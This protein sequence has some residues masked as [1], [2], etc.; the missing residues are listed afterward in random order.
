MTPWLVAAEPGFSE[1]AVP[2]W[3]CLDT[4]TYRAQRVRRLLQTGQRSA[5]DMRA[6]L[7]DDTATAA[8]DTVPIL[9]KAAEEQ[10]KNLASAHPDLPAAI[11]LL[12]DWNRR[13]STDA[14]GMA[15]YNVWWNMVRERTAATLPT[16]AA[17]YAFLKQ[18]L[19]ESR[20]LALDAA[21]DAVRTLRNNLDRIDPVWGEVH[22]IVRGARE[23]AISGAMS[24]EPVFVSGDTLFERG[25]WRAA[26]GYG[27][28]MIVQF[29]P[30]PSAVSIVPFGASERVVSPH[31]TDQLDLFREK[32]FKHTRYREEDVLRHVESAHGR[33]LTFYPAGVPGT[34]VIAAPQAV[35]ASV[36]VSPTPPEPLTPGIT[37]FSLYAKPVVTPGDIVFQTT[38]TIA[39]VPE[40][41]KNGDTSVLRL[42]GYAPGVGW[43]ELAGQQF[44]A[45]SN[46]F[47]ASQ[48]GGGVFALLGPEETLVVPSLEPAPVPGKPKAPDAKKS[49][50]KAPAPETPQPEAA[51]EEAAPGEATPAAPLPED[52]MTFVPDA[53]AAKDTPEAADGK[54]P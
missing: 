11:A 33:R 18:D 20:Q 2:K 32:R 10:Q 51:P 30:A 45:P 53:N 5:A 34:I 38:V 28:A 35:T 17:R 54:K 24:G 16:D 36:A 49:S 42:Y 23:E 29:G 31:Y 26:Y 7:Y 47:T 22:R 8:A 4:D 21:A 50:E 3:L 43:N 40:T 13:A 25:R 15:F 37:A 46:T 48:S 27:F 19:P 14:T 12:Q 44:D 9:L 6:L 41:C 39:A 1:D 52:P